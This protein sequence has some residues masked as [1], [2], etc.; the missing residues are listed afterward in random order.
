M[1]T[2]AVLTACCCWLDHDISG[3]ELITLHVFNCLWSFDWCCAQCASRITS[4]AEAVKQPIPVTVLAVDISVSLSASHNN[5]PPGHVCAETSRSVLL[6]VNRVYVMVGVCWLSQ[7]RTDPSTYLLKY[8]VLECY[9]ASNRSSGSDSVKS[10]RIVNRITGRSAWRLD[11]E[12]S[13]WRCKVWS[14]TGVAR[15]DNN[16]HYACRVFLPDLVHPGA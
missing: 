13:W 8:S 14:E 3:V 9:C 4:D 10:P 1:F 16:M 12:N 2:L 7:P 5:S 15:R 6:G 11:E